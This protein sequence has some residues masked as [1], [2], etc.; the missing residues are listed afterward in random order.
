M[1]ICYTV[2]DSTAVVSMA[3]LLNVEKKNGHPQINFYIFVDQA[4]GKSCFEKMQELAQD[5]GASIVSVDSAQAEEICKAQH[6]PAMGHYYLVWFSLFLPKLCP[7]LDRILCLDADTLVLR[8]VDD[9][10]RIDLQGKAFGASYGMWASQRIYYS[11]V[12]KEKT[13]TSNAGVLLMDL[14][15]LRQIDFYDFLCRVDGKKLH[16]GAVNQ[17]LINNYFPD[18]IHYFSTKY[19]CQSY[20]RFL[21]YHWYLRDYT[22]INRMSKREFQET[23]S[24][25]VILHFNGN[26]F[27]R[28]WYKQNRCPYRKIWAKYYRQVFHS[29]PILFEQPNTTRKLVLVRGLYRFLSLIL[30][31][32]L[33][34]G[35]LRKIRNH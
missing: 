35:L 16:P 6:Y 32:G 12:N 1:N 21:T 27:D 14:T 9:L 22:E 11:S 25:S 23:V 15:R 34:Y 8:P 13:G 24:H 3:S 4:R 30:P 33:F 31:K 29:K 2:F 28:P 26:S 18:E 10:Y 19:N 5:Y 20:F 7:T 17:G